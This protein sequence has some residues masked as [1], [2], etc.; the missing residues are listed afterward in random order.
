MRRTNSLKWCLLPPLQHEAIKNNEDFVL[1]QGRDTNSNCCSSKNSA[2]RRELTVLHAWR[3]EKRMEENSHTHP[4]SAN[5]WVDVA[6]PY[7][8]GG[9]G[10]GG[11]GRTLL[12]GHKKS[13]QTDQYIA[14]FLC[15][16]NWKIYVAPTP[17][18]TTK[19]FQLVLEAKKSSYYIGWFSFSSCHLT[20]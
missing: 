11:V 6:G 10:G 15:R 4:S 7:P 8:T 18:L 17:C 16:T 9:G 13:A 19:I 5:D 3:D 2:A 14:T 12:P 1:Q 20:W